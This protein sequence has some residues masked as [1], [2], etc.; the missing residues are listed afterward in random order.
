MCTPS[1]LHQLPRCPTSLKSTASA[2][3]S[4]CFPVRSVGRSCVPSYQPGG[5]LR[6]LTQLKAETDRELDDA[7]N[8]LGATPAATPVDPEPASQSKAKPQSEPRTKSGVVRVEKAPTYN[9]VMLALF[10]Q[11]PYL[12]DGSRFATATAAALA[13]ASGNK[14]G[15]MTVLLV[16]EK[17]LGD[18]AATRMDMLTTSLR[19]N[20]CHN[21]QVL[22]QVAPASAAAACGEVADA[23]QADLLVVSC[24]AVHAKALDAN[25]LAEFVGCP[26]MLLP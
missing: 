23:Q 14:G 4:S 9:H 17:D 3:L 24:D 22:D 19:E 26:I 25:H 2:S 10:D 13:G 6:H 15:N 8:K 16:D 1:L 11:N 5:R 20:G 7:I 12:S 18:S 21:F